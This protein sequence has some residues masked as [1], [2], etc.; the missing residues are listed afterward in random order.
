MKQ[1]LDSICVCARR[2]K[3]RICNKGIKSSRFILNIKGPF[4]YLHKKRDDKK[5]RRG[6]GQSFR[7]PRRWS[8]LLWFRSS[9]GWCSCAK[10]EAGSWSPNSS[11]WSNAGFQEHTGTAPRL[12]VSYH[13]CHGFLGA[14]FF[15]S[16]PHMAHARKSRHT[17]TLARR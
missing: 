3:S 13:Y 15:L 11:R 4:H 10:G 5:G 8:Q 12:H 16:Y 9:C 1:N 17:R 14:F 6:E 7:A 2:L